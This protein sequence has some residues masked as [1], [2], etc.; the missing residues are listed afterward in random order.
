MQSRTREFP[1]PKPRPGGKSF[2]P[3]GK[4]QQNAKYIHGV[5]VIDRSLGTSLPPKNGKEQE[6][7]PS[8]L[9]GEPKCR[10]CYELNCKCGKPLFETDINIFWTKSS[11][12]RRMDF[13][14]VRKCEDIAI[15]ECKRLGMSC[16]VLRSE[17]HNTATE[18]TRTGKKTGR[19]IESDWHITLTLGDAKDKL[20]LQGHVY[21]F[22]GKDAEVPQCK[23]APGNRKILE[24]H[25]IF[26]QLTLENAPVETYWGMNGSCGWVLVDERLPPTVE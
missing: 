11:R 2:P 9:V 10:A 3:R 8:L 19:F 1:K 20:L 13:P 23:L 18:F 15:A 6:L 12:Y 5:T 25:E 16:A 22:M 14:A 21:L 24:P 4:I 7:I 26:E 17:H